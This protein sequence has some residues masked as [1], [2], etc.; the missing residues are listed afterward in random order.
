MTEK[1][2]IDEYEVPQWM[3][4]AWQLILRIGYKIQKHKWKIELAA[5]ILIAIALIII[6]I[7]FQSRQPVIIDT[8]CNP[9][10]I[11]RKTITNIIVNLSEIGIA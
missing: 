4:K 11:T 9:N 8:C 6:A 7:K 5:N 1:P 3:Y 10:N 2:M